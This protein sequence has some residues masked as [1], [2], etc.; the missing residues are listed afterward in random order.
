[1]NYFESRAD[2]LEPD[3]H[4]LFHL[5]QLDEPAIASPNR[6]LAAIAA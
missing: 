3:T 5:A 1:M 2:R 4:T 6:A